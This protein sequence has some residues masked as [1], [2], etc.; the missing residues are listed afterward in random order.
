MKT[1]GKPRSG[2]GATTTD[3]AITAY[4]Q[5]LSPSF[6]TICEELRALIDAA[7]PQAVAKVWHGSPVWFLDDNPVV[8]YDATAKVVKLLFW[9]GQAFGDPELKPV[10]K[11]QAAEARYTDPKE[12][13]ATVIRRWLKKAKTDV[14]DS[15][16]FFKNLRE[17]KKAE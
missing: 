11:Y 14:F 3:D 15:R 5:E 2:G 12:V 4:A 7:L 8:G 17:K 10:G 16:A 6:R 1:T 13:D 9:N